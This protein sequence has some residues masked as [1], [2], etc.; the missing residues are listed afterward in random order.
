MECPDITT[1]GEPIKLTLV[2][3]LILKQRCGVRA[4]LQQS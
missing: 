1:D 4:H 2:L 3:Y